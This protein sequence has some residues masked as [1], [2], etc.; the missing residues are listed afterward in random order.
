MIWRGFHSD[1]TPFFRACRFAHC[2]ASVASEESLEQPAVCGV[3]GESMRSQTAGFFK[4]V[5][6]RHPSV[7]FKPGHHLP[8]VVV[9]K[10]L[11]LA[12]Q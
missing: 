9:R 4:F 12:R 7:G 10:P 1:R 3:Q 5:L 6:L 2:Q 11:E 8:V